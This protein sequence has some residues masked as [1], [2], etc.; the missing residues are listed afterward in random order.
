[1]SKYYAIREQLRIEV[2]KKQQ[3]FVDTF[4]RDIE[5]RH[6]Q[7]EFCDQYKKFLDVGFSPYDS[8]IA[9]MKGKNNE[10]YL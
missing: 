2:D 3:G 9:F 1:M 5:R 8:L 6:M 10:N 4:L 7:D